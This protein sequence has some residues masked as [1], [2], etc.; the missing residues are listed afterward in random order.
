MLAAR[1][2]PYPEM[3][4]VLIRAGS[5]VND[6]TQVRVSF[7]RV[8]YPGWGEEE[9]DL[10][11]A[12]H[13]AVLNPNPAV[14][15]ALLRHKPQ[16]DARVKLGAPFTAL[17]LAATRPGRV[18]HLKALLEAG[19]RPLAGRNVWKL[20]L[21]YTGFYEDRGVLIEPREAAVKAGL[22]LAHGVAPDQDALCRALSAGQNKAAAL[23]LD[24]RVNPTG[25]D[26]KGNA[27]LLCALT[28]RYP[29]DYSRRY[30]SAENPEGPDPPDAPDPAVL[31]RLLRAH[32]KL[33]GARGYLTRACE[34]GLSGS[35][36]RM[37][38]EAGAG[39]S[40]RNN[41]L[42]FA[43]LNS[44]V[45]R[46]DLVEYLLELG[47]SPSEAA[48]GLSPLRAASQAVHSRKP[49]GA[50]VLV[51]AGIPREQIHD[52]LTLG[53]QGFAVRA[54]ILDAAGKPLPLVAEPS[55]RERKR[56]LEHHD[57][58]LTLA[59]AHPEEA[60]FW[61]SFY[62][63]ATP[64][65]VRE[66]IGGRSLAGIRVVKKVVS[67][68]RTG[69]GPASQ[70]LPLFL[71]FLLFDKE[72]L[73]GKR[74]IRYEFTALT[75][76]ARVT[77][78]PEVIH[79][80]VQAGC[81]VTDLNSEAFLAASRNPH[82]G[83][84]EAVL[85]Y[86]PDIGAATWYLGTPLHYLA[87]SEPAAFQP[88][89]FRALLEAGT[90]VNSTQAHEQETPLM[91]AAFYRNT[92][93]GRMLLAAG[94]RIDRVNRYKDSALDIAVSR[95]AYDLARDLLKA[96]GLV[97]GEKRVPSLL[98]D[99]AANDASDLVLARTL[100]EA[101]GSFVPEA[102]RVALATAA[103]RSRTGPLK[104]LLEAGATIDG[105]K[106]AMNSALHAAVQIPDFPSFLKDEPAVITLLLEAGADANA[107]DGVS[108]LHYAAYNG[109]PL[110]V[111]ALLAGGAAPDLR[112]DNG[113][114]PL[115]WASA[116]GSADDAGTLIAR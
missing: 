25:K 54:G 29:N 30:K 26:G 93:A 91:K 27:M 106:E 97:G 64:E 75:E 6:E 46:A 114:T 63:V 7:R 45:D 33:G 101:A 104:D 55:E 4:D 67:A 70:A 38:V 68:P 42:M 62:Q 43:A 74:T 113:E 92:E 10:S 47:F 49:H 20:F 73:T 3:M 115:H 108:A 51:Q 53:E 31:G 80:L 61:P 18:E 86:R 19:A 11:A 13:F 8:D 83:V 52:L 79:L 82:P 56:L 24:A 39:Y 105:K 110:K 57:D 44:Y 36:A 2:S 103:K 111:Q 98:R 95:E 28:R 50:R 58:I 72:F 40:T 102:F 9:Q 14:L 15:R 71:P 96:G 65:E 32:G 109:F 5:G 85:G 90:D 69:P 112:N 21:G 60:V 77:L 17:E 41:H 66:I 23:L 88:A 107:R 78:Y 59:R 16:L 84:L 94:A 100:L 34:S 1:H 48:G 87:G 81:K 22:L 37:L 12:L 89:V 76:A 35:V 99:Y 116:C